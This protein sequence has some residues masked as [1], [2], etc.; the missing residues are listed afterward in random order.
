MTKDD[1]QRNVRERP[2]IDRR[3]R[4]ARSLA[5]ACC[6]VA[7]A[8]PAGTA[9]SKVMRDIEDPIADIFA[10]VGAAAASNHYCS[11][12]LGSPGTISPSV[13][14]VQLSSKVSGGAPATASIT[15]TNASFRVIYEL[16]GA[17]SNVPSGS[18]PAASFS[19]DLDAWGATSLSQLPAGSEGK[20]KKG[21]T[22]ISMSL[23]AAT[24]GGAFPAGYYAAE[25]ILRCE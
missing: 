2:R 19:G 5:L 9:A 10:D 16:P 20:L 12:V 21:M 3:I 18:V 23:T 6:L 24:A 22:D 17:F 25:S 11:I 15:T 14:L 13:D 7:A 4:F 1:T 8:T